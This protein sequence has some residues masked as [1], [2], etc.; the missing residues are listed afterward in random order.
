MQKTILT[1]SFVSHKSKN[2]SAKLANAETSSISSKESLNQSQNS[3]SI[4]N[5]K[6]LEKIKKLYKNRKIYPKKK[7]ILILNI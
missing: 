6:N 3:N 4:K 2:T 1:N 7:I 5:I